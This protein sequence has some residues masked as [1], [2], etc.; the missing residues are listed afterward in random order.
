M[1]SVRCIPR[2]RQSARVVR[3]GVLLAT[4]AA[5]QAHMLCQTTQGMGEKVP[6]VSSLGGL[7]F[8]VVGNKY[9]CTCYESGC[10]RMHARRCVDDSRWSVG[11]LHQGLCVQPDLHT[12]VSLL[13]HVSQSACAPLL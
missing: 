2:F 3:P 5:R 4:E 10:S 1:P 11:T 7:R 13:S 9:S 8:A 12:R 6:R